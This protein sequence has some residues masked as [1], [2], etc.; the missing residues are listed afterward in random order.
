MK[1]RILVLFRYCNNEKVLIENFK[2][3][4]EK[5]GFEILPLYVKNLRMSIPI[6]NNLLTSGVATDVMREY[7]DESISK[8]EKEL[9]V[10]GI[11]EKLRIEIGSIKDIVEDYLK[12][13]DCILV[14]CS[15]ELD[16]MIIDVLK[17]IYKPIF[18][19]KN[20][21]IDYKNIAIV[22]DDGIKI[23]K[24][25]TNFLK[26]IPDENKFDL[27]SWNYDKEENN[28]LEYLKFKEKNVTCKFYSSDML[29]KEEFFKEVNQY[30]FI[31][32]GNLSRSFLFEKITKKMGLDLISNIEGAIFIG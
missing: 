17:A 18:I 20:K 15:D 3:L 30:D 24:S 4:K 27:L 22:S 1:K 6:G 19:V 25:V 23:N 29:T 10:N 32:M 8:I 12:K 11:N 28:L 2:R 14:D 13:T 7:E 9:K 21:V 16:E 26:I 5:Y 31:I